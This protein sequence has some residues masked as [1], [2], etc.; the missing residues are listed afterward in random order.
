M[1]RCAPQL[2]PQTLN[3]MSVIVPCIPS[4]LTK[5][6]IVPIVNPEHLQNILIEN[7]IRNIDVTA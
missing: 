4:I 6:F 3:L 5:S 2:A 1:L 7:R